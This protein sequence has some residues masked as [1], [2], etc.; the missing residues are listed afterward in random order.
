M[1]PL[2]NVGSLGK[3]TDRKT[4]L[5]EH[6][7]IQILGICLAQDGICPVEIIVDITNL[8]GVLV[9]DL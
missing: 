4:E 3:L 7:K 1:F 2:Q 6:Q 5:W 8:L 9:K